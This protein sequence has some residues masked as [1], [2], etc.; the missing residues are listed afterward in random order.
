VAAQEEHWRIGMSAAA[1]ESPS[2]EQLGMQLTRF[3]RLLAIGFCAQIEAA[4]DRAGVGDE[5]TGA[6]LA[7]TSTWT[8][9]GAL[10]KTASAAS[11]QSER[12]VNRRLTRLVELGALEDRGATSDKEYRSTGLLG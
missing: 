2:L 9:A 3:E 7:R 10:K 12:T 1:A 6:V 5:V 4:R 11:G 8:S